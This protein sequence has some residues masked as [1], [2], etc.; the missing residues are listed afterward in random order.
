MSYD[1]VACKKSP[2][3]PFD[4]GAHG[5]IKLLSTISHR[6]SSGA[7]LSGGN[8]TSKLLEAIGIVYLVPDLRMIPALGECTRS[9][10]IKIPIRNPIRGEKNKI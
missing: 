6:Q 2:E 4:L 5:K 9:S 10:K 8:W 7:S 1:Y 3:C